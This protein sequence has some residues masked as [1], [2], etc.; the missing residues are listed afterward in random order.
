MHIWVVL[1]AYNEAENLPAIFD[2]LS[3]VVADAY[4][5]HANV[6][7]VDDGSKDATVEIARKSGGTI[8]VEVIENRVNQGLASTFMKGMQAAIRKAG[9]DDIIV[10]MDAD[11]THLPGQIMRMVRDLQEGRDVVVASRYRTGSVV[12]GVPFHRR[13]LSRGMSFLFQLCFPIPGVRDYSCGYRAYRAGFLR[14]AIESRG[15]DLFSREGFAC[16]VAILLRLHKEGAICSEVPLVL[17]YDQKIGAS[18]M[19]VGSTVLKTFGVLLSE[20]FSD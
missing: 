13:V 9:D 3:K 12:R 16:M 15:D 17:R 6:I 11:N 5:L 18:K 8:P 20:R 14:R 2:G 1:P 7:L 10:C 19:R 4:N